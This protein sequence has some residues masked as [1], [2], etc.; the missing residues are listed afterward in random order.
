MSVLTFS[1]LFSPLPLDAMMFECGFD[2]CALQYMP[3]KRGGLW[4]YKQGS[5]GLSGGRGKQ[6][7]DQQGG[8]EFHNEVSLG[9]WW[10]VSGQRTTFLRKWV[11]AGTGTG[12]MEL[13]LGNGHVTSSRCFLSHKSHNRAEV[14]NGPNRG[15]EMRRPNAEIW[16]CLRDIF[17]AACWTR[18]RFVAEMGALGLWL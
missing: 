17:R 16:P 1:P 10:V 12:W 14:Y 9:P 8:T 5:N 6:A 2:T 18:A 11:G 15:A 13:P 3:S 7:G 4:W